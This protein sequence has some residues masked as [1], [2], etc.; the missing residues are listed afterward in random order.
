MRAIVAIALL[1]ASFSLPAH[2]RLKNAAANG[3]QL[4]SS[5]VV[6]VSP[7]RAFEALGQPRLWWHPDHTYSG[8][9]ANLRLGLRAG[10]CFCETVPADGGS[11]EHGRVVYSRP[12]Q[13]LRLQA[14]LGPLQ[15]MAVTGTLTWSLKQVA[16]GTQVTQTYVVG[17]YFPDGALPIA[18]MVDQ[19]MTMQLARFRDSLAAPSK[20]RN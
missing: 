19:V 13:T 1:G 14:A 4:E 7:Q 3:F 6:P 12:G 10:D 2:A 8:S 20:P 18:P 16:G 5:V 15:S 11:I 9:A 17:G